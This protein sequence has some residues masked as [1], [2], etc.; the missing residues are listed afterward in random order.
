MCGIAGILVPPG[1]LTDRE[2]QPY[3]RS[4]AFATYV[5]L[6]TQQHRGK[7]GVG[8]A[9]HTDAFRVHKGKGTLDLVFQNKPDAPS[10]MRFIKK[11]EEENKKL[12][13]EQ[14]PL[15]DTASLLH[16]ALLRDELSYNP[17]ERL[18]GS[19]TKGECAIGH[20]RYS[21]SGGTEHPENYQ[22]FVG[23][24]HGTSFGLA[25]NGN[26]TNWQKQKKSLEERGVSFA[27]TSDTELIAKLIETSPEPTFRGAL[28]EALRTIEGAY[29]LI[30]LYDKT[31]FAARDPHGWRPLLHAKNS[32]EVHLI[33]SETP[34][35]DMFADTPFEPTVIGEVPPGHILEIS[36]NNSEALTQFAPVAVEHPC[37]F[38]LV[39]FQ[40]PDGK[41]ISRNRDLGSIAEF[42]MEL[43][44]QLGREWAYCDFDT[45][46]PVQDSANYIADGFAR[47]LGVAPVDALFRSHY[48]GR[49]FIE[50]MLHKRIFLQRIKHNVIKTLVR[51]K[52]VV[53][54]DDSIMRG[55]TIKKIIKFLQKAGAEK[56]YVLIAYPPT[57]TPCLWGMDFPTQEELIAHETDGVVEKIREKIG[58]PDGLYYIS[59]EGYRSALAASKIT[60]SV[61][62]GCILG[63]EENESQK[64]K[65]LTISSIDTPEDIQDAI[66]KQHI[67]YSEEDS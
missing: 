39:Y 28:V 57:A 24:F 15:R 31:I 56:I 29:S 20:T 35:F 1:A 5:M 27:S 54:I 53:V 26:L 49:T 66:A 61:C 38:E 41:I 59:I 51:G 4:V 30:V 8:I 64:P 21:T 17:L 58:N 22:P 12:E 36:Q 52:R 63:H 33:A 34:A 47:E 45:V 25:H 6:W 9:A 43:G 40:R 44:R 67:E 50:P 23:I 11:L 37:G 46:I 62:A 3:I 7:E 13:R 16:N 2:G 48:V 60:G 32:N 10:I 65:L 19:G 42:R 55:T 18:S 14:K